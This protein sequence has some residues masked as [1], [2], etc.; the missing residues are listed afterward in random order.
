M[1]WARAKV[2]RWK[3]E[4]RRRRER[5]LRAD[6]Y[7]HKLEITHLRT[8]IALERKERRRLEQRLRVQGVLD[9]P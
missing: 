9:G 3:A 6:L 1:K 7:W 5:F 2:R 8:L 4:R